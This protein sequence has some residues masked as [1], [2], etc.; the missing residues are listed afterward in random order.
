MTEI[1]EGAVGVQRE[2]RPA[3]PALLRIEAS[4]KHCLVDPTDAMR[5]RD[6]LRGDGDQASERL[7]TIIEAKTIELLAAPLYAGTVSLRIDL[8]EEESL[9]RLLGRWTADGS[10]ASGSG[11]LWN[12]WGE[13]QPPA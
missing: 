12:L 5:I 2:I 3:D 1:K 13:L 6:G 8:Q 4:G 7:A 10:I 9:A 11:H